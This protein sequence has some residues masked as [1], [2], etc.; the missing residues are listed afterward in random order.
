[1]DG[2][3]RV[4]RDQRVQITHL[5]ENALYRVRCDTGPEVEIHVYPAERDGPP[6]KLFVSAG[7]SLDVE[8]A[9]IEIL[10]HGPGDRAEGAYDVIS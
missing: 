9:R 7:N 8:G 4:A 10:Y 5:A 1:M 3:W 6:L 2:T